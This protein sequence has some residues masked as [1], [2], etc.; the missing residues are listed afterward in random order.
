MENGDSVALPGNLGSIATS[1]LEEWIQNLE[2][3]C[4]KI[5]YMSGENVSMPSTVFRE[6]GMYEMDKKS[7]GTPGR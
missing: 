3:V 2:E 7:S 6:S 5:V 1:L 4:L